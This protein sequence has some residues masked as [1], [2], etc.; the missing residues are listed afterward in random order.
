MTL[1][2]NRKKASDEKWFDFQ[3]SKIQLREYL[4]NLVFYNSCENQNA[5]FSLFDST[6]TG[7][8]VLKNEGAFGS[9]FEV[10]SPIK[11]RE[12]N[13]K[14][15][16]DEGT[17]SFWASINSFNGY[18]RQSILLDDWKADCPEGIYS[19]VLKVGKVDVKLIS[20]HLERNASMYDV[21]NKIIVELDPTKYSAYVDSADLSRVTIVSSIAGERIKILDGTEGYNLLNILKTTESDPGCYPSKNT[22]ILF[23]EGSTPIRVTHENEN[24][25]SVI[26]VEMNGK[27]LSAIWINDGEFFDS[28]EV[29][30]NKDVIYFF[31][32]GVLEDLARNPI[33]RKEAGSLILNG[34]EKDKYS[35]DEILIFS[36]C[37][38]TK[39]YE[40][41]QNALTKYTRSR[42]YFDF[43][44]DDSLQKTNIENLNIQGSYNLHFILYSGD[45]AYYWLSGSWRESDGSFYE[46]ND[47]AT[48]AGYINSFPFDGSETKIRVIFESDGENPCYLEEF[49]FDLSDDS[50]LGD[51]GEAPAILVG[52]NQIADPIDVYR[53]T[54]IIQTDKGTTEIS[55]EGGLSVE[56][57]PCCSFEESFFDLEIDDENLLIEALL[58]AKTITIKNDL[59]IDKT[60]TLT[61]NDLYLE[62]KLIL[63]KEGKIMADSLSKIILKTGSSITGNGIS[64]TEPGIYQYNNGV[65]IPQQYSFTPQNTQEILDALENYTEVTI[66]GANISL[67][68]LTIEDSQTLTIDETSNI[69]S[70]GNLQVAGILNLKGEL[71]INSAGSITGTINVLGTYRDN[72]LDQNGESQ[73][74]C[75]GD[76]KVEISPNSFVYQGA[77]YYIGD[78]SAMVTIQNGNI[79]LEENKLVADGDV[80]I[81][82]DI[83]FADEVVITEGNTL[84]VAENANIV[85]R[86]ATGTH[87]GGSI[88]GNVVYGV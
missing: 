39:S 43:W 83:S 76:G 22:Q 78:S 45:D 47:M 16:K 33:S 32:N 51:D 68:D 31:K 84:T 53:K 73:F 12:E 10:I 2:Y 63:E 7:V 13:F 88:V 17:I 37:Q 27:K 55:F 23:L 75:S 72:T 18:S 8:P 38:N 20:F 81:N 3:G 61:G 25:S 9:C 66:T 80:T 6:P 28:F 79:I 50:I 15:I 67:S 58:V 34:T 46:S 52:K 21:Y 86:E 24:F 60:I 62:G 29:S 69:I 48:F 4:P 41:A 87:L 19:F 44:F 11:Y 1:T 64:L 85:L 56:A 35:F 54:L 71:T 40:A 65:W 82:S 59:T 70:G 14:T 57:D 5:D 42:P 74:N 30:W 49:S 26:S 36:K 77:Y